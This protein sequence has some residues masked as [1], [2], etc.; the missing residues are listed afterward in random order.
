[1][2]AVVYAGERSVRVETVADPRVEHAEDTV[3]RVMRTAVCGTDLHAIAHPEQL[4]VGFVLGHEFVGE[5]VEAGAGVRAHA[6]GDLVAGTN[7]TACGRCWWCRRGAHWHCPERRFFGTGTAFGPPLPGA[8]AELVRVPYSDAVLHAIPPGVSTDAAIFLTDTLATGYAAAQRCELRPGDTVAIVGGGPIGQLTS[9]AAQAAGAGAV[10]LVEPVAA[11]RE[12]AQ[13]H[14]ALAVAPD[15][16]RA[17]VDALTDGRGADAVVDAAGGRGALE[18]ALRLVRARGVVVGAGVQDD[19]AWPMPLA[20][21]FDDELTVRFVIG[22]LMRDCDAL[23]ALLR[24]GVID[25]TVLSSEVVGL[26][27]VPEA[28]ARMAERSTL[29]PVVAL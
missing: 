17:L 1:M 15:G 13:T 8:Q 7:Y 18:A 3:V 10:V 19:D 25:P 21:A 20:V 22:D 11:R 9:L 26:D 23:L 16:A 24:S 27:G 4:P 6:V 14:G 29:K 28:Y 5:V 12:L 2:R